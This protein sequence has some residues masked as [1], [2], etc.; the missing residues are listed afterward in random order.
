MTDNHIVS[1]A[2][3]LKIETNLLREFWIDGGESP[4]PRLDAQPLLAATAS[5]LHA[6][7]IA[8]GLVPQGPVGVPQRHGRVPQ[9][10]VGIP[11]GRGVT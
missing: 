6:A 3:L 4:G 8:G 1:R 11:V 9:A 10:A 5:V 7:G 2:S